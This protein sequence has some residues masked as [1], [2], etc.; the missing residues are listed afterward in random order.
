LKS[1]QILPVWI[2]VRLCTSDPSV[3]SYYRKLGRQLELP[4]KVIVDY[5]NEA[6]EI[7]KVN[8]WLNYAF[9]LHRCREMGH[10]KVFDLLNERPLTKDELLEFVELVFGKS[11][12]DAPDIHTE[13][14]SFAAF[15][16][17]V[18]D[19]EGKQW[20]P[21]SQKLRPWIDMKKLNA[22]YNGGVV[23]TMRG[24]LVGSMDVLVNSYQR[25]FNAGSV[26]NYREGDG[27]KTERGS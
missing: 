13:W 21:L 5:K 15:L 11:F 19:K 17:I 16:A 22:T 25:S 18:V 4:L 7:H 12:R 26:Q 24:K 23:E 3:L 20:N 6:K 1:L 27:F 8:R 9:P 2:I 10:Q 14:K